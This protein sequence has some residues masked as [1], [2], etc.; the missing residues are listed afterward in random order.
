MLSPADWQAQAI[1]ILLIL[2][3]LI[4]LLGAIYIWRIWRQ[5]QPSVL[6]LADGFITAVFGWQYGRVTL[7]LWPG[8]AESAVLRPALLLF[9]LW[10]LVI[11]SPGFAYSFKRI[12][13]AESERQAEKDR[14]KQLNDNLARVFSHEI[15]TPLSIVYGYIRI[16]QDKEIPANI[17]EEIDGISRG[18]N[19][20]WNAASLFDAVN[21]RVDIFPFILQD[22]IHEALQSHLIWTATRHHPGDVVIEFND[23]RE[24][25]IQSDK[26]KLQTAVSELVR[27]AI[28]VSG[29]GDIVRIVIRENQQSSFITISV[30]DHNGGIAQDDQDRIW[31]PGIQLYDNMTS[32]PLEGNGNGLPTVAK[33]AEMLGGEAYLEQSAVGMGSVFTIRLPR[34]MV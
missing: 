32:R 2:R 14:L 23:K 28:K 9:A 15:H 10:G 13:Q 11:F 8:A 24:T 3:L 7:G 34:R 30:I 21:Q 12:R 17:T 29:K 31:Q 5:W 25:S 26:K 22:A 27:N 20:L 18:L 19:R 33:I 4:S 1:T 16:L 6:L